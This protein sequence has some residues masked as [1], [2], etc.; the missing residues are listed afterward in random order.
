MIYGVAYRQ[1]V[2]WKEM[3]IRKYTPK[4]AEIKQESRKPQD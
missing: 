3:M 2:F 1:S 4:T